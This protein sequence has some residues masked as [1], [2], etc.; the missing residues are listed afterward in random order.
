MEHKSNKGWLYVGKQIGKSVYGI[1][2]NLL[3]TEGVKIYSYEI[4]AYSS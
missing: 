2:G 4:R 1:W 3:G